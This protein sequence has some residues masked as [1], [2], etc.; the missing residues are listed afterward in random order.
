MFNRQG[1]YENKNHFSQNKYAYA[2]F[3]VFY[4]GSNVILIQYS[5][6]V[7]ISSIFRND[8][9]IYKCLLRHA[10]TY[11]QGVFPVFCCLEYAEK[12]LCAIIVKCC[13]KYNFNITQPPA[14]WY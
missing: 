11:N 5:L 9:L 12:K 1:Q 14:A 2:L 3:L 4:G 7:N 13:I 8:A 10:Y 6:F